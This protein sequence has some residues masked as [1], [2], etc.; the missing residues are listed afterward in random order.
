MICPV[1]PVRKL[2]SLCLCWFFLC[3]AKE[4]AS[5]RANV[6]FERTN[7]GELDK[8]SGSCCFHWTLLI[9]NLNAVRSLGPGF[10]WRDCEPSQQEEN[11]SG[12]INTSKGESDEMMSDGA[13]WCGAEPLPRR[14]GQLPTPSDCSISPRIE[15]LHSEKSTLLGK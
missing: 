5:S 4:K 8:S 15:P 2:F 12:E 11:L 6:W 3:K 1:F 7:G 14:S 10:E 9:T 13:P